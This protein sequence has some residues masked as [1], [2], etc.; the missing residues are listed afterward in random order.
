MSDIESPRQVDD[1]KLDEMLQAA[2]AIL[3][4]AYVP[5]SGFHVGAALLNEDGAIHSAVNVENASYPLSVCA[6]R[7]A[8]AVMVA[9]GHTKILAVAVATNAQTPTPP[10]G[11][12]RQVLWEFGDADTPVVA[13]GADGVRERWRLGDLL[14]H[15]FGPDDLR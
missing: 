5:Y 13:E 9:S 1:S 8:A 14:P 12:C 11:G 15:A 2:R 10:C 7:N 3:P 4:R 6:E